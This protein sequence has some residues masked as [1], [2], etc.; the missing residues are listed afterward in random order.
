MAAEQPFAAG[1]AHFKRGVHDLDA[2]DAGL[3]AKPLDNLAQAR[4]VALQHRVLKRELKQLVHLLGSAGAILLELEAVAFDENGE[5]NQRT[6]EHPGPEAEKKLIGKPPGHTRELHV[7]PLRLPSRWLRLRCLPTVVPKQRLPGPQDTRIRNDRGMM[8]GIAM[9]LPDC[10]AY[11][12]CYYDTFRRL[13]LP[14]PAWRGAWDIWPHLVRAGEDGFGA[15]D[16]CRRGLT[17]QV[18][19]RFKMAAQLLKVSLRQQGGRRIVGKR[20]LGRHA[21][22]E[23]PAQ[24]RRCS[25]R[26]RAASAR[27]SR[28]LACANRKAAKRNSTTI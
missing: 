3:L 4:Q 13:A 10:V 2:E 11:S 25:S 19:R 9:T 5:K 7:C 28:S 27:S 6:Q 1:K 16:R 8:L 26:K 18:R 22:G 12:C 15:F 17:R 14:L 20:C 24:R 23:R 21:V